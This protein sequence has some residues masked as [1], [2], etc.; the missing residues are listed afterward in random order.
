MSVVR[1]QGVRKLFGSTQALDG[2][3]LEVASGQIHGLL[4]PNGAGKS[5][6]IRA[7]LGLV[8]VDAGRVEVFG[9]DPVADAVEVHRRVAYVPSD[10]QLWPNL[11]GGEVIDLL[12]RLRGGL[13]AQRRRELVE[14]FALDP[15]KQISSYSKGNRQKVLL[16]P[17]LAADVDLLVLDE[18]T[19]G[20]DPLM[21]AVFQGCL[22][23]ARAAGRTVLLSSHIIAEV[24]AVADV[25][26]IVRRGRVVEHGGLANLRHLSRTYVTATTR[27]S[28]AG[29]ELLPGVD[30]L[31]MDDG[32]V[33]FSVAGD[34]LDGVMSFLAERGIRTLTCAP[35]TLEA[36]FMEHYADE[37]LVGGA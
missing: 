30:D 24:E 37:A 32:H 28:V 26:T 33:R 6:T 34:Q 20:L 19:A 3:D 9:R 11:T 27:R 15:T 23:E 18:P 5:T 8:R 14:R 2:L 25:V 7:V 21:T 22:R 10:T 35:P 16:I 17:A 13:D 29:I 4:G 36:L 31:D 12:G 1:L